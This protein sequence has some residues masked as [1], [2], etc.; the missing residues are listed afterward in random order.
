[1]RM[2]QRKN[3]GGDGSRWL[4]EVGQTSWVAPKHGENLGNHKENHSRADSKENEGEHAQEEGKQIMKDMMATIFKNPNILIPKTHV[5]NTEMA[6]SKS[7]DMI[8]DTNDEKEEIEGDKKRRRGEEIK[9]IMQQSMHVE[10]IRIE[11]RDEA[12]N[13]GSN[14]F[15][16][17]PWQIGRPGIMSF[18][19]WNCRGLGNSRAVPT[20]C[21]LIR[22]YQPDVIFLCETL[23]H[24]NIIE[25]IRV[26]LGFDA[27][28]AVDRIGRSGGLALLWKHPFEC[29]ILNYSSNF[30]NV[31]VVQQGRLN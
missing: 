19:S 17:R 20:L 27:A 3:V 12:G 25:E 10:V 4:R 2:E 14:F 21:D 18:I 26:R 9:D 31:E 6:G 7:Q 23:V 29:N 16:G 1:M 28:F 24:A 8:D 11:T 13:Q 22:T 5:T 15:T 30:I